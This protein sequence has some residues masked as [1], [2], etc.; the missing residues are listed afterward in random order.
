MLSKELLLWGGQQ[1]VFVLVS[2]VAS[3]G[4]AMVLDLWLGSMVFPGPQR[5]FPHGKRMNKLRCS[6]F[7]IPNMVIFKVTL[8]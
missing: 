3:I 1:G 7:F 2:T 8:N 4:T 5:D 6:S